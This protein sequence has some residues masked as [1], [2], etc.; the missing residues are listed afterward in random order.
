M[1]SECRVCVCSH[2]QAT[3]ELVTSLALKRPFPELRFPMLSVPVAAQ[4]K[5]LALASGSAATR[6]QETTSATILSDP[7]LEL[8]STGEI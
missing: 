7:V 4:E 3:G 2:V 6:L 1:S 5:F 8:M